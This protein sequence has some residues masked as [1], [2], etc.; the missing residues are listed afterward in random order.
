ML[1]RGG[2]RCAQHRGEGERREI[3]GKSSRAEMT[4][5]KKSRAD[6]RVRADLCQAELISAEERRAEQKS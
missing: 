2:A 5:E 4:G 3:A 6:N 1:V